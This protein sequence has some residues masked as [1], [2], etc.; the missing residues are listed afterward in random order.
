[1][2]KL[3]LWGHVRS[4]NVQKV[5]W[6]LSELG[7]E[8]E[9]IDAGGSFGKV[10]EPDYL[11]LNPNGL[12]P[13]LED[14]SAVLWESN[15][16]V[17]YLFTKYGASPLQPIDLA[18]RARADA[19]TDW[20]TTT[21]WP[22]VRA[23]LVQLVRTPEEKRDRAAIDAAQQAAQTALAILD[24]ELAKQ[25]YVA[26]AHF[27]WGDIAVGAATQRWQNLPLSK[28]TYS[29]LNAWY[30]RLKTRPGFQQFVDLPLT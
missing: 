9:R 30:L 27:T 5:L 14:G 20:K 8:Y 25:P 3:K 24:R 23:L 26:G 6:A 2:A 1:M 21:L 28:P 29:A 17:R 15:A 19:W 16:I 4:I 7:L 11:A 12:V 22:H 10:R 18:A 13:T